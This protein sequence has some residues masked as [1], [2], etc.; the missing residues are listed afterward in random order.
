MNAPF[1]KSQLLKFAVPTYL[2]D[3]PGWVV[4]K[5]EPKPNQPGRFAKVPHYLNGTKRHGVQG[6][7]QD[8]AHLATFDDALIALESG[9]Y[10]GIGLAMLPEWGIVGGDFDDCI[11]Y[12]GV[13][14]P[15]VLEHVQG[16]YAEKS[17]S[18]KGIR[19]FWRG[20]VPDAKNHE[21]GI[22]LFC[23][24]GFLTVTGNEILDNFQM[25]VAP[26]P[27]ATRTRLLELVGHGQGVPGGKKT[28]NEPASTFP[29]APSDIARIES[30]LAAIPSDDYDTWLHVGMGLKQELGEDGFTL[31][32]KW[33]QS[34]EEYEQEACLKKWKNGIDEM[35][36]GV[37]IG[38][39]FKL[40]QDN[41]W[42]DPRKRVKA[43]KPS[44]KF[45]FTQASDIVRRVYK[46]DWLVPGCIELNTLITLT[47]K[48]K[49]YKSFMALDWA[50]CIATGT[51][52]NGRQVKQGAVFLIVGE[53]KSGFW[54][55]LSA[56]SKHH[57]IPFD[58][59]PIFIS[60]R[61]AALTDTEAASDVTEA[62]EA[63]QEKHGEPALIIVDTLARNFGAEDEN[64]TSAM[65]RFVQAVDSIRGDAA[66]LIVHHMGH[67]GTRSRGS[68]AL[69]GAIDFGH[70]MERLTNGYIR[71]KTT[72]VKDHEEP[73]PMDF[74]P[75]I[76]ELDELGDD[77]K[78]ITSV[79]LLPV[80]FV[81]NIPAQILKPTLA[82]ALRA[83][84]QAAHEQG[85]KH[86]AH[87]DHWR[88]GFNEMSTIEKA[89]TK[90][91]AFGRAKK[92][93]F[94]TG[95]VTCFDDFYS[96]THKE[97]TEYMASIVPG[98][99]LFS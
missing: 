96:S 7:E 62:I 25:D 83:L 40:A 80:A 51:P 48:P 60:E 93:L 99:D 1:T 97:F 44:R 19:A 39:L 31:W 5:K 22:E 29:A 50:C 30:A 75:E 46:T 6:G 66:A 86:G 33:S 32:D 41:G 10:D 4:W 27:P 17:P 63:L 16:T 68:S 47:A 52:W 24:K 34:S 88:K 59:A 28:L 12:N 37:G 57:G 13:I 94:D 89:N 54:K 71:L 81:S 53:G 26:L 91:Q 35:F 92:E 77:G 90:N 82:L 11:D 70:Q 72:E 65:N 84:A 87:V 15:H 49:T 23:G 38:T 45:S 55:R 95:I 20:N 21:A 8:R 18:D 76:I 69:I 36:G 98:G 9:G 74:K 64:S 14:A 67:E 61:A 3:L 73:E 43:A 79:V 85:N 78:P 42:Q 56:W 58:N 2:Q